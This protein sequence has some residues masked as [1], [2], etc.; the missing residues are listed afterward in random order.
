MLSK[1]EMFDMAVRGLASQD[2]QRCWHDS[3]GCVYS[4]KG[5]HCAWGWVDTSIQVY[6]Y[7]TVEQLRRNKIGVAADLDDE[8]LI[9]ALQLQSAHDKAEIPEEMINNLQALADKCQL[10]WPP[11]VI[12]KQ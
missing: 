10:I 6:S 2:W 4:F 12:I 9:F 8:H 5:K 11:D 7:G 1:Q 3:C